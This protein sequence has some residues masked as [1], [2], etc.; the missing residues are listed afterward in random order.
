MNSAATQSTVLPDAPTP[1]PRFWQG[2]TGAQK[3]FVLSALTPMI[4]YVAFWSLLP[5]VWA[6][7]LAFFD[8]SARRQGGVVLGLGGDNP[9]VGLQHFRNMLNF[10]PEA[11]LEVRLFHISV[12]TTLMF[13]FLIVPLNLMITLPLAAMIESVHNR[14]RLG[15]RTIFFLPVVTSSV[16]VAIMWGYILHPQRGLLNAG[17]GSV[18]GRMVA[19]NWTG[20][21]SLIIGPIPVALIAVIIAYLWQDIGYNLIIFI[22]ALQ[23]IP[24]SIRDAAIMD[25][26]TGI[27][28]FRHITL[29]LLR[30]TILLAAI[31]TMISAFQVFDIFQVMTRGGP[32]NQTRVLTFDI[33]DNA[34]RFQNMGWAAATSVV[35]FLIVLAISLLQNRMLRSEWEY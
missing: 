14:L 4:L 26:A 2:R 21:P 28:M 23:G 25:G 22:A 34:F 19:I 29:P 30:P 5:I 6:A 10:S 32:D 7:A 8:Y 12:K 31:L 9:F 3:V 13:A 18:M 20:D 1:R 33:Y 35:L 16:G 17:L 24:E 11:P 15:L 27:T